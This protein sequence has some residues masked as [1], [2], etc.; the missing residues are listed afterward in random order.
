MR[1]E[2]EK[3]RGSDRETDPNKTICREDLDDETRCL[4]KGGMS[5]FFFNHVRFLDVFSPHAAVSSGVHSLTS[6]IQLTLPELSFRST[7]RPFQQHTSC[8]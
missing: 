6:D 1:G 2:S 7:F 4:I 8:L 3:G 5:N